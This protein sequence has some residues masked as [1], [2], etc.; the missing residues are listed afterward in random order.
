MPPVGDPDIGNRPVW[1]ARRTSIA[2]VLVVSHLLLH[3]HQTTRLLVVL[4]LVDR[5]VF[6]AGNRIIDR[7]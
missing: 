2:S 6:D 3:W 1:T 7:G 4:E 5:P